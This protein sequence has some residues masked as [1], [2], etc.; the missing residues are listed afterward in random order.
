M[1]GIILFTM[2]MTAV[3]A[4]VF[5]LLYQLLTNF[6]PGSNKINQDLDRMR[7]EIEPW[8]GEL[9]PWT[10]EEMELLSHNQV[11]QAIKKGIAPTAKGILTSI[12]NEPMMAYS[13][14]R[15]VSPNRNAILLVRTSHHEWVYRVRNKRVE[16][17]I[18]RQLV[19]DIREDGRFYHRA[20]NQLLAEIQRGPDELMLPVL[21]GDREVG[22]LSIPEET[23]QINGRAFQ[24]LAPMTTEEEALFLSLSAYELIQK[25]LPKRK[26]K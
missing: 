5:Y 15:Y 19:G 23:M 11:N 2:I 4:G 8:V 24:L 26:K 10:Q 21:V 14:K 18:D 13:Y 16:V 25:E 22:N 17:M 9:V 7:A 3:A 12:Y 1:I 20:S 6:Q